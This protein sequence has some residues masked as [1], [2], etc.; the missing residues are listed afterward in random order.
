MGGERTLGPWLVLGLV[1]AVAVGASLS[2]AWRTHGPA[3]EFSLTST[4]YENGTLGDPV[5]FKLSDYRGKTV[6]LDFMAVACTTCRTVTEDILKPLAA[7]EPDVVILSIDTWS[8]PGSGN[9]FG[10]ESDSDLVRLQNQTHVAW[11]H[12]R[13]TERAGSLDGHVRRLRPRRHPRRNREGEERVSGDA[14]GVSCAGG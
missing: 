1:L 2:S 11:R 8:D 7:S 3:P 9:A 6:V 10:G 5:P 13:D 14:P 12:A 4:G